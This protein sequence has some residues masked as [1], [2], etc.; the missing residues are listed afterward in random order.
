MDLESLIPS[1]THKKF[2]KQSKLDTEFRGGFWRFATERFFVLD[3]LV[4]TYGLK[5]CFHIENDNVVYTSFSELAPVFHK[6]HVKMAAP[7]DND[8]RCIPS[9]VY[10]RDAEASGHLVSYLARASRSEAL[11]DMQTLALYRKKQPGEVT[12]LP[13][14]PTGY[15][16]DW[17]TPSG[18]KSQEPWIY[19]H[20]ADQFG[21]IFDAAALG[22]F[23]GGVDGAD[24]KIGFI[25]ESCV[26]N[27]S[28]LNI[29][30]R[31]DEQGRKIPYVLWKGVS[32]RINNLHI[33]SKELHKF[34]S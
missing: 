2:L 15:E 27:P 26:F 23:I 28:A 22:Q 12:P 10:F 31:H 29:D 3:E 11:N 5:D 20:L 33:H 25:N 34:R 17:T 1:K 24:R 32:Y 21:S 14:V 8:E 9:F 30:W 6:N 4:S 13:I 7:F 18:Q 19:T 16:C